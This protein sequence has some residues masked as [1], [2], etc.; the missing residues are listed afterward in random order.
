MPAACLRSE[1]HGAGINPNKNFM[2]SKNLIKEIKSLELK[3]NRLKEGLF[4]AEGPK[5]VADLMAV[6][7]PVRL[8]ATE[9]WFNGNGLKA[10]EQDAVVTDGELRKTSFLQHPQQVIGLFGI[11]D[12]SYAI[13][14]KPEELCLALDKVQDP[15]NLGTIIRIADWFGISTV[16]CG[17]GTA[18][19]F[20]PKAVQA[21]MG[22]I[23]HV[24][25]VCTDLTDLIDRLPDDTPVY[26][27]ALDGD[28]I[29]EQE[30]TP[31]GLIIMGNE[32]NGISPEVMSRV[33]RKILIPCYRKGHTAESLNVAIATAV[34]CAEFR[35]RG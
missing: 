32:G 29:Y 24:K 18:D 9:E 23:A 10:R 16:F 20:G 13:R 7:H 28:S 34:T 1:T 26:G 12:T 15:G 35:R 30:L 14:P 3:K 31:G 2:I 25:I 33:N 17:N 11:P 27:T 22:S 8:I 4:V 21:T 5:V 19:A 6:Y